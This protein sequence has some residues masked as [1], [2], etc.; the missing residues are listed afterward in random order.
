[1]LYTLAPNTKIIGANIVVWANAML[2]TVISP[3]FIALSSWAV[4][5]VVGA[6]TIYNLILRISYARAAGKKRKERRQR[7][8][9][10][11]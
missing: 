9:E 8:N 5:M 10:N 1:M 6:L 11:Q 2:Q 4:S 7:E 3:D